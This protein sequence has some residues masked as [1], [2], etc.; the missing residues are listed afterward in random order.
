MCK[1]IQLYGPIIGRIM[2]SLIFIF[3]GYHKIIGFDETVNSMATKGLPFSEIL[4]VITIIIEL[5][6]GLLLL[7][8][9][10]ARWAATAIFLF[11][12]P[13]TIVFHPFWSF[14]GQDAMMQYHKFMKNLAIMGGLLYVMTYGSGPFSLG[15]DSCHKD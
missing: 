10:Q 12:I 8:G 5:G 7:V 4:L 9:W 11:I 15:R 3:A 2:L 6:G 13:V 14:E 1:L